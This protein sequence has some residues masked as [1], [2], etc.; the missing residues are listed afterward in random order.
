MGHGHDKR[1]VLFLHAFAK[2]IAYTIPAGSAVANVGYV[3]ARELHTAGG[4]FST[5]SYQVGRTIRSKEEWTRPRKRQCFYSKY[6]KKG[7]LT[8]TQPTGTPI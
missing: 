6:A 2:V 5:R 1:F 3:R 8:R 4:S 7:G